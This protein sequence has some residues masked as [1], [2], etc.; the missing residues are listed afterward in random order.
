FTNEEI[1][2]FGTST[3]MTRTTSDVLQIQQVLVM[4]LRF[5][6]MDPLRI[7]VAATLAFTR[8]PKLAFVFLIIVPI[9]LFFI[10]IIL[11]KVN[12]L[13]RSIQIKTDRLNRIFREGL[14]GIRVIRAFNREE[15]EEERFDEANEDYAQTSIAAYIYMSFLDPLMILLT[16]A[17]SIMIIWFGAQYIS[18]GEMAVGNLVAFTSYSFNILMGI[19][20]LSMIITMIP[21]M[22]VAI[23]R[24]YQILDAQNQIVDTDRPAT[25]DAYGKEVSL[26]FNHV[27]FRYP[28][29]EKLAL[30][31]IDFSLKDGE[32]IAIIG[33]TGAGKS[34][35]ANLILR[36]YD[37][38]SGSIKINGLDIKHVTQHD[39]REMI[40][41]ATK[42]PC[43][44]QEPFVK[45]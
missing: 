33:G 8:E 34:T 1:D 21:R 38:E 19:M 44:F 36:L 7:L 6:I 18:V 14:T 2:Q 32:K 17:T 9:L 16:S 13:F 5:L 26:A 15:Y 25:L 42:M 35:L 24:V 43:Y 23:E 11:R 22:Q 12:P 29:A 31:D 4:A 30:K 27:D 28:G 40:G 3:L 10:V 20:M 41:F 45:T 37:I 39:L